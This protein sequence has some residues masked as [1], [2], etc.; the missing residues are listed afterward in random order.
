MNEYTLTFTID[1]L[2]VID[3]AL[4]NLAFKKVAPLINNINAQ[5]KAANVSNEPVEK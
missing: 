2:K 1:E 4:G 5:I 3:E